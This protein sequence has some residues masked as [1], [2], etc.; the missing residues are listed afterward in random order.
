MSYFKEH[1]DWLTQA[2]TPTNVKFSSV[3]FHT[4]SNTEL[5]CQKDQ[6]RSNLSF[7]ILVCL[8]KVN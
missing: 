1:I 6:I 8:D 4:T 3:F 5:F 2:K 7:K